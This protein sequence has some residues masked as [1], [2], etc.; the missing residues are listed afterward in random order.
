MLN[1]ADGLTMEVKVRNVGPTEQ[2]VFLEAEFTEE[3]RWQT[4]FE[5]VKVSD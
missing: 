2:F 1:E 5:H 4:N 3:D